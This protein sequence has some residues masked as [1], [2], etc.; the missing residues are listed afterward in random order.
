MVAALP[1]AG[2]RLADDIGR[3][4]GGA[5]LAAAAGSGWAFAWWQ[6]R[7]FASILDPSTHARCCGVGLGP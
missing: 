4:A 1:G 7:R 3:T 5:A 6:Q 2:A